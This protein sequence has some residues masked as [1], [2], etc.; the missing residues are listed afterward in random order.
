M[1]RTKIDIAELAE[2]LQER[3]NSGPKIALILGSRTGALYRSK[4]FPEA[5][6]PYS[7]RSKSFSVDINEIA[8]FSACYALMKEAK[9]QEAPGDLERLLDEKMKNVDFS[10]ADV[11]VAELIKQ[12][13]FKIIFSCNPDDIL[14][15]AFGSSMLKK[16]EDF[17][18]LDFDRFSL[19][20]RED[21]RNY[22]KRAGV[23]IR[24]FNRVELFA[25]G[26]DDTKVQGE[27]IIWVKNLLQEQWRIKDV[28]IV[29]IDPKWDHIILSALP[30]YLKTIWFVNEDEEEMKEFSS[31]YNEVEEFRYI[32]GGKGEY[33][34]FLTTLYWLI[35]PGVPPSHYELAE[36]LKNQVNVMRSDMMRIKNDIEEIKSNNDIMLRR[37]GDIWRLLKNE[38]KMDERE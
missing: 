20:T 10:F 31:H 23:V 14:Y 12:K 2:I 28:L 27:V 36:Q 11:C 37:L 15:H 24:L 17:V 5:M 1:N 21:I 19:Y 35:N 25:G 33:E 16:D 7:T 6:A 38:K 9:K 26:L 30:S 29:G 8:R 3:K 34:K 4:S 32:T 18:E 22:V 13:L